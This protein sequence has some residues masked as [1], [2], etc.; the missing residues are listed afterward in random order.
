MIDLIYLTDWVSYYLAILRGVDPTPIKN[1]NY[2]KDKL[3]KL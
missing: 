2:L 3:A 1:I